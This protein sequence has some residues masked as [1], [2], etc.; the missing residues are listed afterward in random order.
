MNGG[1]EG[2]ML[3]NLLYLVSR[4]QAVGALVGVLV[5]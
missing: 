2:S 4:T 3:P 5:F 1:R